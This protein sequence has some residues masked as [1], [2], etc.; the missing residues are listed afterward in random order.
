[1]SLIALLTTITLLPLDFASLF[2]KLIL[3]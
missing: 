3:N 2:Y 1:M